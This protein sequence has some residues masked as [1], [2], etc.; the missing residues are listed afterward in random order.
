MAVG[1]EKS[2]RRSAL[3]ALRRGQIVA[4]AREIVAQEGLEALT[5]GALERRL[6]FSRGVITY[7]FRNKDEIVEAVLQSAIDE[8]NARLRALGGAELSPE[9]EVV[10]VLRT[11]LSG[12]LDHPE[13]GRILLSFWGRIPSSER[14]R[15]LNAELYRNYRRWSTV[16]LEK[17]R[18]VFAD[19]DVEGLAGLLVGIVIGI[20][21]QTY[22]DPAAFEPERVLA[23]ACA[24]VL[25]RLR[26]G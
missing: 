12:F 9:A 8:I 23:E 5:I 14:I 1:T 6:S 24:C 15:S 11:V 10:A 18:G 21:T 17:H 26:R 3:R 19:C 2:D 25:A 4:A 22:F 13:A 16:L 7:H 20:A